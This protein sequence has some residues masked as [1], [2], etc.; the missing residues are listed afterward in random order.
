MN[1]LP[2]ILLCIVI[3]NHIPIF[4][5]CSVRRKLNEGN[6]LFHKQKFEE[7]LEKYRDALIDD[8]ESK[9][10]HFNLGAG[11]YKIENYEEAIR[12]FEKATYSKDISLQA[13]AYYNIG[14]SLYRLGRLP[15]AI[16]YYK[17]TLELNPKDEDAK[18]NL[19]FVQKKLKEMVNKQQKSL[20]QKQEQSQGKQQEKKGSQD[21]QQKGMSKEDAERIL[22][23]FEEDERRAQKNRKVVLPKRITVE[24]D[25]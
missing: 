9:E 18:Y 17:K 5:Y 16:L 1:I 24:Q 6:K 19:E 14:N 13:K 7:A 3:I 4:S 8:P 12:E 21:K 20:S 15:E 11:L 25:W 10:T 2:K 22:K 23:K